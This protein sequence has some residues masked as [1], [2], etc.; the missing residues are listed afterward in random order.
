MQNAAQVQKI[1]ITLS[2]ICSKQGPWGSKCTTL[3]GTNIFHIAS[4]VLQND[5]N[6]S[7]SVCKYL[8]KKVE[9]MHDLV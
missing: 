6:V 5:T 8:K 3:H 7:V 2:L 9:N 1:D 4:S